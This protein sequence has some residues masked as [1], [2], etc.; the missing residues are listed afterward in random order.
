MYDS[1]PVDVESVVESTVED[2]VVETL[3]AEEYSSFSDAT[4]GGDR[5][6]MDQDDSEEEMIED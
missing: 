5:E 2:R 3:I 6:E 4:D 1:I